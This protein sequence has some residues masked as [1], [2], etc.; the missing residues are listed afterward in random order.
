MANLVD[1][2]NLEDFLPAV[3]VLF[4]NIADSMVES[5][6]AVMDGEADAPPGHCAIRVHES[7]LNMNTIIAS[8]LHDFRLAH[9]RTILDNEL[10]LWVL[11]RSTA[12][13][14]QFLLHEYD[15]RRWVTN[16]RFTEGAI[17]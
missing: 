1:P 8:V 12:W 10:G 13:F 17:F 5:S 2:A 14:S 9:A 11:P 15:D 3:V 7:L 16:F 6:A 4:K